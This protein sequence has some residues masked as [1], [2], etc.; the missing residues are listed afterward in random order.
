[1]NIVIVSPSTLL[2]TLRTVESIWRQE[3]QNKNAMEIARQGGA[4]YDKFVGFLE[5]LKSI[6][7]RLDQAKGSYDNAWK[8]I[9]EGSG[10]LV[11]RAEK[12][13]QLGAK[14]SKT[15]PSSIL[16]RTDLEEDDNLLEN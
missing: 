6:G 13:K 10:N 15:L 7:D 9:K 11:S 8:K 4:L 2:A 12:I 3:K 1:M 14:V 16:N 5:D